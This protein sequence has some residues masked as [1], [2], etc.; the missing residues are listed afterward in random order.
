MSLAKYD[1]KKV[2]ESAQRFW[3]KIKV[4]RF[5]KTQAREVLLPINVPI[6]QRSAAY[7]TCPKLYLGGCDRTFSAA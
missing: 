7:G 3:K 5:L 1:H 4:S 2:E 6:P